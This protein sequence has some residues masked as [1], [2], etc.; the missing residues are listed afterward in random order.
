MN[1][2]LAL[3]QKEIFARDRNDCTN[4]SGLA[5]KLQSTPGGGENE[6]P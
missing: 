3:Q 2:L 1:G 6:K 4:C 5:P